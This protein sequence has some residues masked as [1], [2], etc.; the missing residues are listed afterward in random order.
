MGVK[1]H[2]FWKSAIGSE[3]TL[4]LTKPPDSDLSGLR[5]TFVRPD[6]PI[7]KVEIIYSTGS[8]DRTFVSKKQA[9]RE[10]IKWMDFYRDRTDIQLIAHQEVDISTLLTLPNRR[11]HSLPLSSSSS[12]EG[13]PRRLSSWRAFFQRV[14]SSD[15]SEG[16]PRSWRTPRSN[17]S[18][19]R[20]SARVLRPSPRSLNGSP[21]QSPR[22]SQLK[23]NI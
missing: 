18:S 23:N 3:L 2:A 12:P 14:P 7:Y 21:V 5:I 6:P 20:L 9:V 15:E 13:S 1:G 11:R 10:M 19:P 16:S 22:V 17:E 4:N 8:C